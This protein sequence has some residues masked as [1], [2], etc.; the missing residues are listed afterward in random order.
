MAAAAAVGVAL[1]QV[2]V[3]VR[4]AVVRVLVMLGQPLLPKVLNQETAQVLVIAA[5]I[6]SIVRPEV[7]FGAVVVVVLEPRAA[8]VQISYQQ[9]EPA[10]AV[11][12]EPTAYLVPI[13]TGPV[14]AVAAHGMATEVGKA[15]PEAAEAEPVVRRPMAAAVH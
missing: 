14:A 15:A 2:A 1:S 10:M 13:I 11:W 7:M 8:M 3:V 5:E 4:V 9:A 6:A 12:A